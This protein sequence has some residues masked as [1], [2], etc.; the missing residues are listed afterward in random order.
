MARHVDK[1]RLEAI[2]EVI[3]EHP[4][5]KASAIAE[6]LELHRSAV[7]RALP[8]LEEEGILLLEDDKGRLSFFGRRQ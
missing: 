8:A 4:G 1:D 5:I 7:I 2:A 6:K 3:Q